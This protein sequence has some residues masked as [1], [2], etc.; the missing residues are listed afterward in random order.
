MQLAAGAVVVFGLHTVW[1]LTAANA[2]WTGRD[3]P[4]EWTFH[5]AAAGWL[6]LPVTATLTWLLTRRE[7]TR[8]LG[9]GGVIGLLVAT[10]AAALA[11]F[12][13]YAPPW[14]SAGWTGQGWS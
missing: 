8:C 5:H 2:M 4:G 13:G 9:R 11:L 3:S 1:G 14:V 10:I 12:T 7:R 6:L